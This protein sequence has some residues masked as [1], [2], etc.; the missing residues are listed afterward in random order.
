[1]LMLEICFKIIGVGQEEKVKVSVG[2]DETSLVLVNCCYWV[3][4][5]YGFLRLVSPLWYVLENIH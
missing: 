4:G 3:M 5:A 1:M 2:A